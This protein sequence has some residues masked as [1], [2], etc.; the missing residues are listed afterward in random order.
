MDWYGAMKAAELRVDRERVRLL[1]SSAADLIMSDRAVDARHMHLS[2][3]E[4]RPHLKRSAL[5]FDN[6]IIPVCHSD[7]WV[8]VH[9][10]PPCRVISVYDSLRGRKKEPSTFCVSVG[11]KFLRYV[12]SQISQLGPPKRL[13]DG[14]PDRAFSVRFETCL[15]KQPNAFDCGVYACE[16]IATLLGAENEELKSTLHSATKYRARMFL[17]FLEYTVKYY[18]DPEVA[19]DDDKD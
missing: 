8:V 13:V 14:P 17:E 4:Q 6:L 15:S 10:D 7:H 12:N 18:T 16:R 2:R 1:C 19:T 9:I 5:T 3:D 11:N